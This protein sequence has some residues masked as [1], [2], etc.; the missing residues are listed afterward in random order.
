MLQRPLHFLS[1]FSSFFYGGGGCGGGGS[2]GR[3][4]GGG[5]CSEGEESDYCTRIQN[6]HYK[7]ESI[8]IIMTNIIISSNSISISIT[9]LEAFFRLSVLVFFKRCG[10]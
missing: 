2:A 1:F 8:T 9:F 4:G 3:G 6:H 7:T 10:P 5:R